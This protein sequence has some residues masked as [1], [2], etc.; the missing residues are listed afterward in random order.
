MLSH[1]PTTARARATNKSHKARGETLSLLGTIYEHM[2][3]CSY[4]AAPG[5]FVIMHKKVAAFYKKFVHFT[6]LTN[7]VIYD[8]I[9]L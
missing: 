1:Q 3:I 2:S 5:R 4:V 9:L 7:R 6:I 8:I